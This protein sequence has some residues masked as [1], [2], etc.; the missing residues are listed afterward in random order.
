MNWASVNHYITQFVSKR[1]SICLENK[2]AEIVIGIGMM[3]VKGNNVFISY[4]EAKVTTIV[5]PRKW[6]ICRGI[7]PKCKEIQLEFEEKGF[8]AF[9]RIFRKYWTTC[10]SKET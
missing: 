5:I 9:I 10:N 7:T 2:K 8:K 3:E 6:I 1:N 4:V